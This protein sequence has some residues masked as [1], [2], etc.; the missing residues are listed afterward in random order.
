M[1]II[2]GHLDLAWNAL[3]LGRDITQPLAV[4]RALEG[5]VPA[6]G[7]GV[8]TV[9]LPSLRTAGVRVAIATI[10]AAPH[11][12]HQPDGYHTAEEAYAQGKAQLRYYQQLEDDGEI[13][14]IRTRQQLAESIAG[15]GASPGIVLLLEG[16]EPLRTPADL[17]EYFAVGV[18]I[19]GPAWHATRYAGGTGEPGPLTVMGGELL[20]EM[21]RLGVALDISHLA[22]EACT[23]AFA[24]FP[25]NIIASH[26]NARH[27]TAVERNLT[28]A[29]MQQIVAHGGV[30]GLVL[31]NR[32][33]RNGWSEKD[34]KDAVSL[35]HLLEH[36]RYIAATIG[37]KHL[38]LG[39]DMDG[40]LG[41]DDIPCELDSCADYAKIS[42]A[43]AMSGFTDEEITGIMG[44][45]WARVL[46]QLLPS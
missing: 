28:D 14:I 23:Q 42:A 4:I 17:V 6:H 43:L 1:L 27:I 38:A 35:N 32:F 2:D 39:S 45:N 41:R 20:Q 36:A 44:G 29:H 12:E 8:A 7:A 26:C 15:E 25:G 34:G 18:R 24:L 22:E 3:A 40:G 46:D 30:I 19:V 16:A 9:C 13:R 33:I 11:S 31:Y 21:D 5:E 10:F 37:A